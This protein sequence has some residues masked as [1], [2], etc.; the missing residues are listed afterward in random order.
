M[1][2]V[3]VH[4]HCYRGIVLLN[5][6]FRGPINIGQGNLSFISILEVKGRWRVIG[7]WNVRGVTDRAMKFGLHPLVETFFC[8]M[9]IH[10]LFLSNCLIIAQTS[11]HCLIVQSLGQ[12]SVILSYTDCIFNGE[13]FDKF[14]LNCTIIA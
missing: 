8:L 9:F 7:E 6:S 2:S 12:K 3:C 10:P 11:Y 4:S 14:T 13:T 1:F 5:K